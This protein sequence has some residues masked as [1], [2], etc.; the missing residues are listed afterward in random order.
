MQIDNRL[1]A[2]IGHNTGRGIEALGNNIRQNRLLSI[3]QDRQAK[4]DALQA[5]QLA[6]NRNRL[7]KQDERQALLDKRADFNAEQDFEAQSVLALSNAQTPEEAQQL[8]LRQM[9]QKQ[10]MGLS[11]EIDQARLQFLQTNPYD[12]FVKENADDLDTLT[13]SGHIQVPKQPESKSF[14]RESKLREQFVKQSKDFA[15]Q[16]AAFGRIQASANDPSAAGDLALIF[17]FMKILD[18][19]ST[20]REGEFANA[21]NSGGVDAKVRSMY[22]QVLNGQRLAPAQRADFFDRSQ[23]LYADAEQQHSKRETQYIGLAERNNL[24]ASNVV[25]DLRTANK[26]APVNLGGDAV[27]SRKELNGKSYV[28]INGQWFEE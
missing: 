13:R 15:D 12:A 19:G 16:N 24:D 5:E 18:P 23:R 28:K 9:Q 6:F 22:N 8:I 3:Q 26:D 4:Q 25:I 20:V 27:E 21:Q 14:D 7:V 10:G 1:I 11:T 2:S 17:N